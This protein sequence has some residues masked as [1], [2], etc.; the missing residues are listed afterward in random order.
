MGAVN[1]ELLQNIVFYQEEVEVGDRIRDGEYLSQLGG[2]IITIQQRRLLQILRAKE[3][4]S[5]LIWVKKDAQSL[6]PAGFPKHFIIFEAAPY[7][8]PLRR[9]VAPY[10]PFSFHSSFL[11]LVEYEYW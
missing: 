11:P 5:P 10:P 9:A 4:P 2:P 3:K 8:I 6:W 7:A 1:S